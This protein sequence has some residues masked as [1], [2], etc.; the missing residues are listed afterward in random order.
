M[1]AGMAV[2]FFSQK[3]I[4]WK[5]FIIIITIYSHLLQKKKSKYWHYGLLG[6]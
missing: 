5:H 4:F 2:G 6:V 1:L 3:N